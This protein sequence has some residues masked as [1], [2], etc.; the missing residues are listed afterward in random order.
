MSPP[1]KGPFTCVS[2]VP[3]AGASHKLVHSSKNRWSDHCY[4]KWF[5]L[6]IGFTKS[7]GGKEQVYYPIPSKMVG[8]TFK[9]HPDFEVPANDEGKK[10]FRLLCGVLSGGIWWKDTAAWV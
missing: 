8:M 2:F 3:C 5:Y 9:V 6:K 7:V 4:M 1:F 10:N